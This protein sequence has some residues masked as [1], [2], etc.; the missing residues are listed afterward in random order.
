MAEPIKIHIPPLHLEDMITPYVRSRVPDSLFERGHPVRMHVTMGDGGL[1][2]EVVKAGERFEHEKG[3][4][5]RFR[6]GGA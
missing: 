1:V 3:W 2:V 5:E 6:K 4:F